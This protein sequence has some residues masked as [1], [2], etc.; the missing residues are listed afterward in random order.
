MLGFKIKCSN[1]MTWSKTPLKFLLKADLN[2]S[3]IWKKLLV[4]DREKSM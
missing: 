1:D 3:K 4:T 2:K